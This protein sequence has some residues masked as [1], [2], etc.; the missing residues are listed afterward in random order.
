MS[1]TER[2][3]RITSRLTLDFQI[4]LQAESA[5][6]AE[7]FA[8]DIDLDKWA[9]IGRDWEVL[10]VSKNYF[11]RKVKIEQEESPNNHVSNRE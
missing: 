5:E 1:T 2:Q 7:A 10:D 3:Y 9:E 6:E 11:L 8:T 4:V